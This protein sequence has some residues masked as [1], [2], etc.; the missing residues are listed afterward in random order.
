MRGVQPHVLRLLVAI[1]AAVGLLFFFDPLGLRLASSSALGSFYPTDNKAGGWFMSSTITHIV[2]FKFKASAGADKISTISNR[3]LE[4]KE[5]CVTM[6]QQPYIRKISGGRDNSPEGLQGGLTHAF[7]VE[8]ES[9]AERDY[10][11]NLDPIHQSFKKDIEPFVEKVTVVDFTN[12][13][14]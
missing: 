3:F 7:V 2:L 14:F 5:Q 4:L 11:V 1:L 12:G 9:A 10:Y 13:A 8:F 6:A